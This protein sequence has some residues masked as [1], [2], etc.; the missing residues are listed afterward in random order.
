MVFFP[1]AVCV[2]I[3][4]ELI[5]FLVLAVIVGSMYVEVSYLN[6]MSYTDMQHKCAKVLNFDLAKD[7]LSI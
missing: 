5:V 6:D 1:Q 2:E 4:R 3:M 7:L